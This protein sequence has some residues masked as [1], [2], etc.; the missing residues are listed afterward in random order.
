MPMGRSKG[1]GIK[2][3]LMVAVVLACAHLLYST[4]PGTWFHRPATEGP[5][6]GNGN[7]DA[8]IAEAF[9]NHASNVQVSGRGLVAKV[10]P[11]DDAGDRHQRFIVRLASGQ[12]LL[13]AHNIDL[14]P[15]IVGLR[16]GDGIRFRGE[17]EWNEKGGVLHWTHR[18][19]HRRHPAGWIEHRGRIYQ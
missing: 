4:Q 13:V 11:D 6:I 8:T 19:P 1:S 18:D 10:L 2:R 9:A 3:L 17:Y 7:S 16:A 5:T 14:A 15:K 12:T